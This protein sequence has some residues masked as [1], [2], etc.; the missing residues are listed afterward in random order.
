MGPG[1]TVAGVVEADGFGQFAHGEPPAAHAQAR[2]PQHPGDLLF[3]DSLGMHF[4]NR[5][6][7]PLIEH[8]VPFRMFPGEGWRSPDG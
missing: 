2:D 1:A 6:S 5:G 7:L 8:E 3:V 4:Q